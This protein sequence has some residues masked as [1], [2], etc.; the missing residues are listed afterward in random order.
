[1]GIY[2]TPKAAKQYMELTSNIFDSFLD[3]F[4]S[5]KDTD[6]KDWNLEKLITTSK[7][8]GKNY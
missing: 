5:L 8:G 4:I 6:G 1:M 2:L 3:K 7:N